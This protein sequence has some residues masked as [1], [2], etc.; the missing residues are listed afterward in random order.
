MWWKKKVEPEY[1]GPPQCL[2]HG[3]MVITDFPRWDDR[4]NRETHM[5]GVYSCP[6]EGCQGNFKEYH[7]KRL[8]AMNK[9]TEEDKRLLG[10]WELNT[11]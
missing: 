6:A 3:D 4:E 5:Y 1:T 9:L 10:L 7:T 2:E 8:A 11:K